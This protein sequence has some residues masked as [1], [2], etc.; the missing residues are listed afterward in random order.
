MHPNS[1]VYRMRLRRLLGGARFFPGIFAVWIV[2]NQR[3]LSGAACVQI[4][5]ATTT[6]LLATLP[7]FATGLGAL[8][9]LGWRK[10]RKTAALTSA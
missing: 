2:R 5:E 7:L 9:L 10:K 3:R 4:G 6:P 1:L 8:G